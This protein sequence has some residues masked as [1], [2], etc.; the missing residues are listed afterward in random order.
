M[1]ELTLTSL[2][3]NALIDDDCMH[4]H[5]QQRYDH[6]EDPLPLIRPYSST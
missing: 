3:G 1:L 6:E 4:I 2:W 5:E